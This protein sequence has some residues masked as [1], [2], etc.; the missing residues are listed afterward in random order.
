LRDKQQSFILDKKFENVIKDQKTFLEEQLNVLESRMKKL[1]NKQQS[2]SAR[3]GEEIRD[4]VSNEITPRI[5]KID[6]ALDQMKRLNMTFQGLKERTERIYKRISTFKSHFEDKE[7][8]LK[9]EMKKNVK[10]TEAFEK[11]MT[12][13]MNELVQEYE[14]RFDI[15]RVDMEK[16]VYPIGIKPELKSEGFLNNMKK[17]F[18]KEDLEK[19]AKIIKLENELK[20]QKMLM[21]KLLNE[22]KSVTE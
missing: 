6:N 8:N 13:F 19:N 18:F 12:G 9:N 16:Y 15:I 2:F 20:E 21:K 17:I 11:K 3:T 1:I 4:I 10:K 14:K 22:L 5:L 7:K